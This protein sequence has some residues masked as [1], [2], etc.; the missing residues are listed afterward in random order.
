M[1]D[2]VAQELAHQPVEADPDV[3]CTCFVS[4]ATEKVPLTLAIKLVEESDSALGDEE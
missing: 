1:A 3:R 2:L 4:C